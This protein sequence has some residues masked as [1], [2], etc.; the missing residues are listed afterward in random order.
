MDTNEKTSH[1]YVKSL[2]EG[3][4]AG[5][6]ATVL[7]GHYC[8]ECNFLEITN[9]NSARFTRKVSNESVAVVNYRAF[10]DKHMY[11]ILPISKLNN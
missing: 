8:E 7:S 3:G 2:E 10:L 4:G 5:N 1:M 11:K 9:A 6:G